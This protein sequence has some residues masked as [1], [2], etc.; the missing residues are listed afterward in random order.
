MEREA[1]V[2]KSSASLAF[3]VDYKN[4]ASDILRFLTSRAAHT[5]RS[6]NLAD[7][8]LCVSHFAGDFFACSQNA[9]THRVFN[10]IRGLGTRFNRA[11]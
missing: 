3:C 7:S 1:G 10:Q 6:S 5:T 9:L 2:S 11:L 8:A 4:R